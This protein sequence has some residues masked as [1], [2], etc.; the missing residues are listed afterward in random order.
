MDGKSTKQA[1]LDNVSPS[2]G[3]SMARGVGQNGTR[4]RNYG[5]GSNASEKSK[6]KLI[7]TLPVISFPKYMST[8]RER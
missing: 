7:L 6:C 2:H 5:F 3:T 4:G 8:C 1:H